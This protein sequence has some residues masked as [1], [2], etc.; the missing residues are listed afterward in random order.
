MSQKNNNYNSQSL[1]EISLSKKLFI[2]REAIDMAK[3]G[4]EVNTQAIDVC[5]DD[6]NKALMDYE[7]ILEDLEQA[8]QG[9]QQTQ[10]GADNFAEKTFGEKYLDLLDGIDK[11]N[12]ENKM[13]L[14]IYIVP[15]NRDKNKIRLRIWDDFDG[16][17]IR[18]YTDK[19]DLEVNL[20]DDLKTKF[21]RK[22]FEING[23][24]GKLSKDPLENLKAE[25]F[26]IDNI[27]KNKKNNQQKGS[28]KDEL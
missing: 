4:M 10:I 24:T 7:F 16:V 3:Y 19:E 11:I 14:M 23:G 8:Q 2:L 18:T 25:G 12:E 22:K 27:K 17:W 6:L 15:D 5:F 20:E 9:S 28:D 13:C 1:Q 26:N 21:K